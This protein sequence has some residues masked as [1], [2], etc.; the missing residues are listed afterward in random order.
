MFKV[1]EEIHSRPLPF[2]I[3]SASDLWTD[4]H[5]SK[6]MLS[7]HLNPDIDSASRNA[8]FIAKSQAWIINN[9]ELSTSK[10]VA[11]FGCGPG[12]YTTAFAKAGAAVTGIDFSSNSLSYAKKIAKSVNL[13]I[14]YINQDY[15]KYSSQ[16]NFD[17][18]TMIMCDI[19]ALSP[20]QRKTMLNKFYS[21]LVP[22]GQVL[23]D[24][25]SLSAF[26]NLSE[27]SVYE[28]NLMNGFW[29]ADKYHGFLN[30]F[31]YE[32]EKVGLDK[33]TIVESMGTK[34]VYNWLQ[35]FDPAEL[36]REF[37]EAGFHTIELLSDVAG[38]LYQTGSNEFA[39]IATK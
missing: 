12:L 38:T 24:A 32:Q 27:R 1:L 15:L 10:I 3:C 28:V 18:I 26:E 23:L 14:D 2:E 33:Y 36:I 16:K 35:Y 25:F 39:V 11:D 29:S 20:D 9:F 37:N 8:D 22:G 17:L 7:F 34:E 6:Q 30:S 21:L 5:I 4:D 31:K 13:S 19:C